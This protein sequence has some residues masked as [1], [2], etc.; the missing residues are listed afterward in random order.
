MKERMLSF[1]PFPTVPTRDISVLCSAFLPSITFLLHSCVLQKVCCCRITR[2]SY[3]SHTRHSPGLCCS[4][5]LL[6]FRHLVTRCPVWLSQS[7]LPSPAEPC[8]FCAVLGQCSA[9]LCTREAPQGNL[10]FPTHGK[11]NSTSPHPSKC[12]LFS[13]MKFRRV[14]QTALENQQVYISPNFDQTA[15]ASG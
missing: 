10:P 8:N 1:L 3:K 4:Q 15:K 2:S 9:L 11:L 14:K 12:T 13:E 7:L 6:W 5:E